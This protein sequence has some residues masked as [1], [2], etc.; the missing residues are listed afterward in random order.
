MSI[1]FSKMITSKILWLHTS[2]GAEA[3]FLA[4]G[5]I[6]LLTLRF[7]GSF[8]GGMMKAMVKLVGFEC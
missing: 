8:L 1:I 2:A 6:D 4:L 7:L 5:A 3:F